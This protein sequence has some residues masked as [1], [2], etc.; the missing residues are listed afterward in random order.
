MRT[1]LDIPEKLINDLL[2]VLKLSKKNEAVR[3]AVEDFVRRKKREKLLSL[4]GGFDIEDVS[5][6]IREAERDESHC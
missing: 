4:K 5:K 2:K 6:K 3:I 1:T